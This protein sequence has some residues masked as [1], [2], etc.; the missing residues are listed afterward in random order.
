[1]IDK[2]QLG[3]FY[4]EQRKAVANLLRKDIQTV[5]ND[6]TIASEKTRKANLEFERYLADKLG[7]VRA[8]PKS[9]AFFEPWTCLSCLLSTVYNIF[10]AQS[11]EAFQA[12]MALSQFVVKPK[13]SAISKP[14]P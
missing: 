14:K 5:F 4:S 9:K 2:S 6:K 10:S 7:L 11:D 13:G 3:S 8:N 1:L 12:E